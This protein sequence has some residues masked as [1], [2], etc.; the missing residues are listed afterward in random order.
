MKKNRSLIITLSAIVI[1]LLAVAGIGYIFI[2]NLIKQGVVTMNDIMTTINKVGTYFIPIAIIL[3]VIIIALI[4][5]RNRS[6]KFN[7]WLKWESLVAF[8][9]ALVLTLNI[10]VFVPMSALF[11]LNFAKLD[12]VSASTVAQSNNVSEN[13][14]NEGTVLLKN[15][16]NYLPINAKNINVFGWASTNPLYGGTG[17]GAGGAVGANSVDIYQSLKDAGFKTNDSLRKFYTKYRKTRPDISLMKQDWTLPEPARND[18]SNKLVNKAKNFSDTALVVLGRSGGEGAD[19]PKD[20]GAKGVTY[21]GN[22]GDFKKGDNYLQLSKSERDM[23]SLVN[24]NFKNVIVLI[25][26]SNPMELGFLNQYKNIKGALWMSGPGQKGFSA[27]GKILKGTVNPS[28]RTVDTYVRDLNK[29]PTYN[30]VG[31]FQYTNAPYKYVNYVENI[32]VGYK[33]YETY[34]QNNNAAYDQAVQYPFGYGLSYTKFSQSMGDIKQ[35]VNGKIHFN[36]TVKN[37]GKVAGKDVVQT[38]YTAP[39]TNGGTEKASTNLID[40]AKTKNLKPGESQTIPFTLDREDLASYNENNG[41]AYVL[42]KG[43]YQIQIKSDAHDVLGSKDYNVPQTVTYNSDNKRSSDKKVAK[44]EFGYA[45]G[46]VD[47][48]SRKNNFANYSQATAAPGKEQLSQNMQQGATNVKNVQYKKSNAKM[49]TTN[50]NNN[51]K[52]AALRGKSYSDP[53]WNKL[54]DQLSVKDMNNLI[55]YGGYQTVG[56]NS[57][58]AQHTYDFDGPSGLTSFMVK[59]MNTTAFPAAAMIAATWNKNLAKDCGSMVGKQGSEIGVTGWYGPAMNLHRNAFAG[60]NFE[61]YSED[62][63]LSGYMA[64]NEIAGAK[65]HGVYAYMKHFALNDQETNRTNKLMTWSTEQAIREDYLK[66]FEMAVKDGGATATMSSFNFIGN[67]WAG[68]NSNL[69]QNVLRG[70]WGYRGLVE[71][72]YFMGAGYM[73][74]N[75]GIANGNDLMLSTNGEMGANITHTDNPQTVKNM[76]NASHNILYTVVN[77]AAYK[78]DKGNQSLLLPWQKSVIQFDI[79]AAVIV[80]VLQGIVIVLYRRKYVRKVN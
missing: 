33:F 19:L 38:Y 10:V 51:V 21:N 52:L 50:A 67:K 76:R 32:Y 39:Y 6:K 49:P 47:Y 4:V 71:T 58:D 78:N 5:F 15:T 34:Y 68:A 12:Q 55:T 31:D 2:S 30:N 42:D 65:K 22:K 46:N 13:I 20:M 73:L 62:S 69:L 74:G 40:F 37:T 14:A 23:L 27:L 1:A 16:N 26:A 18:Y 36:V 11:N 56:L 43:R 9:L 77:S 79:I 35:S 44:N 63:I 25:N 41:G 53:E 75:T 48:L 28:G 72:D 57:V 8:F 61:Y 29:T 59:N 66:P 64:A 54:L 7:F 3:V 45:E 80:I 60:R 17:S 24:S 70:E